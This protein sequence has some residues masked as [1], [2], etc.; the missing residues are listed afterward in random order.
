MGFYQKLV[1]FMLLNFGALLLGGFLQGEG[2][3]SEWYRGLEI[4]PWTPPG[5]L[6][7]V[8]WFTIM[9]C[10]SFYMAY[11]TE[12]K[13]L[14]LL[15][16]LF[17]IQWVLNV[18]WNAVFF[19]YHLPA[20]GLVVII[21]LTIVVGWFFIYGLKDMQWKSAL[22]LPYLIWLLLASSLNAYIWLRN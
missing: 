14:N 10:F 9:L 19:R 2:A 20:P 22:A 1:V 15:I 18:S 21:L 5:W 12:L 7:G 13:H 11:A 17:I 8:A 3:R 6:F 4:A 16:I